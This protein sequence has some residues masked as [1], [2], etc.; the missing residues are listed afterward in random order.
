MDSANATLTVRD[1]RPADRLAVRAVNE[2]AFGSP[3]EADLI[4]RLRADDDARFGLVAE[5]EG[6]I[7]G[8]ILF[9][10]LP[11]ALDNGDSLLAVA[12]APLAVMPS[13]QRQ[14]IGVALVRQGL[15]KCQEQGI[16]AVVVLGD[17]AYY[18]RF[19]FS[20]AA[21]AALRSPWSGPYLMAIELEPGGLRGGRGVAR[22]PA[23]FGST[24]R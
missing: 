24:E 22:Y 18:G 14:G 13:R 4:E 15:D 12:L 6:Q 1:E 10:R 19:G 5:V 7:A 20:V 16:P 3:A 11:I 23:A 21:A 2:A 9:S 8:H 17:P